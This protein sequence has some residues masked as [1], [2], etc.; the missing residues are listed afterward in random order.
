MNSFRTNLFQFCLTRYNHKK[1][2][3]LNSVEELR[4]RMLLDSGKGMDHASLR[5]RGKVFQ[6]YS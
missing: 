2:S 1:T 3:Y 4:M 5:Y 6:A